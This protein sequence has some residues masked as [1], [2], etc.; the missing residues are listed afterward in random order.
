MAHVQQVRE[1]E[2]GREGKGERVQAQYVA[3]KREERERERESERER[4]S[5]RARGREGWRE[6][7][8]KGRDI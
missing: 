7:E 2:G 4:A 6:L 5:A 8:K 3:K 1:R